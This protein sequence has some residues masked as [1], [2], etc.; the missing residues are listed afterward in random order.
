MRTLSID[1]ETYSGE[2]IQKA[3][4]YRYAQSPDFEILLFAY[5]YDD[6]PVGI[7]DLKQGEKIP[8]QVLSD[9][10]DPEVKKTAF[11]A[12]FEYYCLSRYFKT[13]LEQWH[14]SMVHAWYCGYAGGLDAVG[15]AM[16]FPEDRR[17]MAEGKALIRYFCTPCAP[18]K[19]NGGR[20][21]NLPGHAPEKWGLFKEYCKQD[22]AVEREIAK[23]LARYPVPEQEHRLWVADQEINLGG[24]ALDMELVDGALAASGH[25]ASELSAQAKQATGL[26]NPNSVAQLKQWIRENADVEVGSLDKQTVAELLESDG[27]GPDVRKVLK[28]RQELAKTSVKKYEAMKAAVCPDGRVRGLLQFYG[29]QRTGRWA[30]R[31]RSRTCQGIT[32][33][34]WAQ[35]GNW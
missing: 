25:V 22:V 2:D 10:N 15:K 12:A 7:I 33:K 18:T 30:G 21:R 16:Q 35:P 26:E 29:G 3:G 31:R 6:A 27:A 32:S 11:N 17:K 28:I 13:R 5:Q 8:V 34:A 20:R 23:R 9:L 14:C 4:L 24:V 19:R 1:L